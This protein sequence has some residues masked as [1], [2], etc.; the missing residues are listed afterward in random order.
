MLRTTRNPDPQRLSIGFRNFRYRIT[1]E[2]TGKDIEDNVLEHHLISL[3]KPRRSP[4]SLHPR[5]SFSISEGLMVAACS[6]WPA[7]SMSS[8]LTSLLRLSSHTSAGRSGKLGS[9]LGS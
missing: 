9:K 8:S 4:S 1:R 5:P 2:L 7:G 6:R 3:N